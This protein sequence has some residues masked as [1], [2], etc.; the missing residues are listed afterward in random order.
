MAHLAHGETRGRFMAPR[1]AA[2]PH[3]R[4]GFDP[5]PI[6]L[7]RIVDDRDAVRAARHRVRARFWRLA[8]PGLALFWTVAALATL[9]VII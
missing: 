9:A 8:L 6:P 4:V 2:R 1:P 3:L 5:S 7:L